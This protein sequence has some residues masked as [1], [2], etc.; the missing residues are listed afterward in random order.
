MYEPLV[1]DVLPEGDVVLSEPAYENEYENP[2]LSLGFHHHIYKY[3]NSMEITLRAK[4]YYQVVNK[5][6]HSINDYNEDMEHTAN[7]YFKTKILDR[8]FFKIWELFMMYDLVSKKNN[9]VSAHIAE[10]PGSFVQATILYREKYTKFSKNDKYHGISLHAESSEIPEFIE[11]FKK[12]YANE[13]PTRLFLYKTQNEVNKN[14]D[15][16]NPKIISQFVKQVGKADLVTADGGFP[17]KDENMQEQEYIK[18]FIGELLTALKVQKLGGNFV[19]KIYETYTYTMLKII[20]MLAELYENVHIAKPYTSRISN[21]EKYIVCI[22]YYDNNKPLI[23]F[24][25]NINIFLHEN[26]NK[27][28][29]DPS[30]NMILDSQILNLFL[31]NNINATNRQIEGINNITEFIKKHNSLG[32]YYKEKR[33]EQI[34]ATKFWISKFLKK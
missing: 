13:N 21:S 28:L 22:N 4:K 25:N 31:V 5:F 10:A 11:N 6:E 9:F 33:N 14:G 7:E 27:F 15:I 2:K 12:V 16:T 26:P 20:R 23:E 34:E 1:F 19:C 30:P 24:F 17:W 3:K 8:A 32:N 18:L 29:Y